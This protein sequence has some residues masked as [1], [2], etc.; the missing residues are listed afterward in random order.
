MRSHHDQEHSILRCGL[1]TGTLAVLF[2]LPIAAL[3]IEL[4]EFQ[5]E[6]LGEIVVS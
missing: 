3:P 5:W 4:I 6:D 2:L 1:N